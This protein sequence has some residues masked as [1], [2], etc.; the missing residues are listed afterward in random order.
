MD[1]RPLAGIFLQEWLLIRIGVLIVFNPL[2]AAL[3]RYLCYVRQDFTS[4]F[5]DALLKI[6]RLGGLLLP[7]LVAGSIITLV[8]G[9]VFPQKISGSLFRLKQ[10][11]YSSWEATSLGAPACGEKTDSLDLTEELNKGTIKTQRGGIRVK[12]SGSVN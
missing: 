6:P 2:I 7:M 8:S 4:S 3:I 12:N 11:L 10:G 5:S 1:R 9:L